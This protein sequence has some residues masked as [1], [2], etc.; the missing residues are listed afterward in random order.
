MGYGPLSPNTEGIYRFQIFSSLA[1]GCRGIQYFTFTSQ[2]WYGEAL[3][4]GRNH[5]QPWGTRTEKYYLAQKVN[6]D[7]M[8]LAPLL[9]NLTSG[10]VSHTGTLPALPANFIGLIPAV[11]IETFGGLDGF[12]VDAIT[13]GN[14]VLGNFV[15]GVGRTYLMFVNENYVTNR[16][17]TVTLDPVNVAGLGRVDKSTGQLVLAYVRSP[18][19]YTMSLP[20]AAGDGE[21]FKVLLDTNAPSAPTNLQGTPQSPKAIALTWNAA[22]DP[23]SGV[24]HYCIYRDDVQVAT[25]TSLSFTNTGLLPGTSYSFKVTAVNG[26]GL[27]SDPSAPVSVGTLVILQPMIQ[28]IEVTNGQV[29]VRWTSIAEADYQLQKATLL[30][31]P[32]WTN[33]GGPVQATASETS[34]GEA[35]GANATFYRVR[36]LP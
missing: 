4:Y 1:Y 14:C 20:L 34:A 17:F 36:V 2:A 6:K 28:N 5:N 35:L 30:G 3:I 21:L 15:D 33:V 27:E 23:Q 7:V 18:G 12:Y 29:L 24:A 26:E 9:M 16:T 25:T 8:T 31:N 10:S 19:Q 22:S 11:D 13:G 32:V